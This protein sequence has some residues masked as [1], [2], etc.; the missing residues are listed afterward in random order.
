M[1]AVSL[2]PQPKPRVRSVDALRGVVMIV[3]ALD[4]LRESFHA[5]AMSFQP[6]DLTRTT[7][8]LF[9]TRWITN[10]CAP[11]FMFTTGI[12]AFFWLSRGRTTAELS[13]F[14]WKRGLWLIVLE[15]TVFRFA[16]FFS[17]KSG[18][19]ML[20]VLWALG[21]SMIALSLLAHLPIRVLAG[22]SIAV[23]ALHNLADPVKASQ[24]GSAAWAWNVLHQPGV[25]L[26]AGVPV[27]A[28]YPL[29]PWFAVMALGF[30]FGPV[31]TLDAGQRQR[32]MVRLGL[33]MTLAFVVLRGLNVYGDP[34]PWSTR[35]PGM[36]VLSCLRCAKYPPSLDF[37]LM[38]LGPALL[39]LAWLDR[40]AL[41]RANPLIV[42][43][44]V[45]LFYFIVH[46]CALRFLTIPM[47]WARY[48]HA[49][50]LLQPAPSMGGSAKLYPA[51][52][53]Y[54]LWVVYLLW[55]GLVA[56]LYPLCRWFGRLKERRRDWWLQYL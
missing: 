44:R 34:Q 40:A 54:E 18:M 16:M 17:L 32:W 1:D 33:G 10:F 35:F 46:F 31:L 41:T 21:W 24:F 12:G 2:P 22:L 23:I 25:F 38:T 55:V 5:G 37:L 53:G 45:P 19:V 28:G 43:G 4:H 49:G 7:A 52:Y 39:L 8:A 51:G 48:G 15:L 36:T 6:E 30:C 47:A 3:M 29:A 20:L 50:F 27:L 11:V 26:V 14:L 9:F 42:F 56:M 13:S